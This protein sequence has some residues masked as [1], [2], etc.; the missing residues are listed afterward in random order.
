MR[1]ALL[2][3]FAVV[4]ACTGVFATAIRNMAPS[5]V[6]RIESGTAWGAPLR[7]VL[8]AQW[9][10][11]FDEG[12]CWQDRSTVIR[13]D[14]PMTFELVA[15]M[16]QA[17]EDDAFQ[18]DYLYQGSWTPLWTA[19]QT[20]AANFRALINVAQTLRFQSF[21]GTFV[22]AIRIYAP[23]GLAVAAGERFGIGNM[24]FYGSPMDGTPEWFPPWMTGMCLAGL[25]SFRR[26]RR[27]K[28]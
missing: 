9:V 19:E 22:E 1:R 6:I 25:V 20:A 4:C 16:L 23:S 26:F 5:G 28:S 27:L 10:G 3:L 8:D 11:S 17:H 7:S 2:C 14:F 18:L 21:D 24:A 15:I 12:V 13:I